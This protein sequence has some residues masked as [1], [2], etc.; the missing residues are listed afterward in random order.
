MVIPSIGDGVAGIC[1]ARGENA[2]L[3]PV[4]LIYFVVEN[5]DGSA[6]ICEESG[7]EVIVQPRFMGEGRFCVIRDP[8]G[9]ICALYRPAN[10]KKYK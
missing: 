1:H 4:W 2:D 3:P 9:A 8:A 10:S 7:G 5:V 6:Q